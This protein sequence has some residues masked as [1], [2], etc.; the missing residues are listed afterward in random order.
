[1]KVILL[2]DVKKVG[3]KGQVVDVSNGYASNFLIPN[4]LAVMQT[5]K[6]MEILENQKEHERIKKEKEHE[7]ALEIA[8]KLKDITLEFSL[9]AGQNGKLFGSIS[10]K[11]ITEKLQQEYGID[12]DKRKF[13]DKGP[14][15]M[16]GISKLQ[17]ELDKG[18]TGTVTVHVKEEE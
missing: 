6:S 11:Q 8:E 4:K 13:I 15:Q 12:I 16:L 18:V 3:K 2:A 9:K 1:M 14:I 10:L 17:L 7:L 5:E